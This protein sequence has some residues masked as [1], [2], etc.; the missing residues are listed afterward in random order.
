M[1]TSSYKSEEISNFITSFVKLIQPDI[2]V[3]IGCQQG[4]SAIVIGKGLP[5]TS[6]IYTYDIFE[7]KYLNFP[8]S[9][10]HSNYDLAI[11]NILTS[12]LTCQVEVHKL[13]GDAALKNHDSID[14]LHIDIC[15]HYDNIRPLL[16]EALPKVKHAVLLEGGGYNRWQKKYNYKPYFTIFEESVCKDWDHITIQENEHNAITILTRKNTNG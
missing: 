13:A 3:E 12:S 1:F 2:V 7:D 10:T 11:S 4:Y 14:L 16:M 9:A 15:N 6:I 5:S 8:Y